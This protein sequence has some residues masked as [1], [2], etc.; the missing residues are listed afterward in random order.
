MKPT[1]ADEHPLPIPTVNVGPATPPQT[2]ETKRPTVR[3]ASAEPPT[4]RPCYGAADEAAEQ[5]LFTAWEAGVRFSRLQTEALLAAI[6]KDGNEAIYSGNE[7]KSLNCEHKVH[8]LEDLMERM[9]SQK[10][11]QRGSA[12]DFASLRSASTTREVNQSSRTVSPAP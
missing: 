8:A 6:K 4:K 11:R 7:R 9:D 2:P 3:A 1:V 12:R 10:K 5:K